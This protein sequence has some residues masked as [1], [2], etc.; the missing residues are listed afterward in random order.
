MLNQATLEKMHAMKMPAMAEAFEHQLRSTENGLEF[1]ERIGMMIDSEW[2]SRQHRRLTRRLQ[3]AK[4]RYKASLEDIDFK[5]KRGLDRKVVTALSSCDW[6]RESR[7]LIISGPTGVGKTYL[8]CAIAERACRSGL[9]AWYLRLPRLLHELAVSRGDG[10]YGRLLTKLTKTNLLIIDD[11]L[12]SPLKENERRDLLEVVEDRYERTATL[13]TTQLPVAS[14]HEAL[15]E[16]THADAICDRLIHCA[17]RIEL[18]GPSMR[19]IRAEK[20]TLSK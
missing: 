13:V 15:G 19:R 6:I 4:L 7:N 1:D 12:L 5:T 14:W 10:S 16:P 18:K 17:H 11:W 20:A 3:L 2:E 9:S 8:A